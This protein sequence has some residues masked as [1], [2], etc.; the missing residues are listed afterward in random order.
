MQRVALLLFC[1]F[2]NPL[3]A[4]IAIFL[5][6]ILIFGVD[7]EKNAIV[8]DHTVS[9][10]DLAPISDETFAREYYTEPYGHA[11]KHLFHILT[12]VR[13]GRPVIYLAGDSTLDNKLWISNEKKKPPCNGYDKVL[14]SMKQDVCYHMNLG[15]PHLHTPTVTINAAVEA[16]CLRGR[17]QTLLPQDQFIKGAIRADDCL[18]V[19]VGGNDIILHPT[20]RIYINLGLLLLSPEWLIRS[21]WAPGSEYLIRY[22]RNGIEAYVRRLISET[23]PRAIVICMLYYPDEAVGNGW[24]SPLLT[25]FGYKKSPVKIQ[26]II[27]MLYQALSSHFHFPGSTTVTVPFY[28]ALDGTDSRDYVQAVEPSIEGGKKLAAQLLHKLGE[29]PSRC[30]GGGVWETSCPP[31]LTS[32]RIS[33]QDS[34]F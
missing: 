12:T 29:K 13:S 19:S 20:V 1:M 31:R 15:A 30:P 17:A 14:P 6:L 10:R 8:A 21:G 27:R 7:R 28:H 34:I 18:V 23:P 5:Y 4:L 22:F 25:R 3:L 24:A 11:P 33:D 26:C 32:M 16:S 2:C 9:I